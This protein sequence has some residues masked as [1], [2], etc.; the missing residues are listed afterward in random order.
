MLVQPADDRRHRLGA[1]HRALGIVGGQR[2]ARAQVRSRARLVLEY[3]VGV[4]GIDNTDVGVL[5]RQRFKPCALASIM[6]VSA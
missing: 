6:F 1:E 3:M 5:R 2:V 4:L